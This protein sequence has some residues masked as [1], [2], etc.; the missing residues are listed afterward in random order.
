[1]TLN[2]APFPKQNI[3]QHTS[4]R[5]PRK[6]RTFALWIIPP[7]LLLVGFG[8]FVAQSDFFTMREISITGERLLSE[9]EIK[10]A[11]VS[12][13]NTAS[14]I[15]RFLGPE[16]SVFWLFAKSE[17]FFSEPTELES[18]SLN[19][20]FWPRRASIEV[21]ERSVAHI[22]CRPTEG[23]CYGVTESGMIFARIP[24]VRGPLILRLEDNQSDFPVVLGSQYFGDQAFL[25]HVYETSNVLADAGILPTLLRVRDKRLY[26]WEAVLGNGPT[27][28][29]S[30]FFVPQN[31]AGVVED[32]RNAT[33]FENL[34]YIDFR[35]ENKVFYK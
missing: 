7:I 18:I 32:I 20:D 2:K 1:M 11:L 14:F 13:I 21:T 29:F 10:K 23:A 9:E 16:H 27:L 25:P 22:I 5:R 3:L 6:K 4:A 17:Y 33:S 24:E 19:F 35:V 28:Y 15:A 12:E 30:G 26:E 8:F 31:L 34:S